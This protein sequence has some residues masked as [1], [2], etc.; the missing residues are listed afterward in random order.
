MRMLLVVFFLFAAVEACSPSG[1]AAL[2]E[3]YLGI[4]NSWTGNSCCG[5]WYGVSCDPETLEV[6][7]ISLR[8]ESEDPIFQKAGRTGY[9]TGSISPE[10][11]KLDRLTILIISDWKGI[12]GEIP[13][14]LTKL[15]QLRVL[16]LVGNKISG[17]IPSDFGNLNRLTVLNLA[18]N[19]ISGTIPNSIVNI[20]GLMHL[21]LRNNQISG[22]VPSDFGK[23][24]MLSRALLSSNQLGGS[25]PASVTKMI[26]LADLD[27]SMNGI[28][29]MIPENIG[30]MPVLS[31]LNLDSN[32]ISG[33]IPPTLI[34]NGGLGILNTLGI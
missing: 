3:P 4:F 27:L 19:A 1:Q 24:E 23:L 5:G 29:G 12:S 18:D 32:R 11:C 8:G 28:S 14:C 31:T 15:S 16:D 2:N 9:M 33:Q 17:E 13:K 34:S 25:I 10:I 30:N 7:E 22:E 6:T 26:R 20:G 21:D